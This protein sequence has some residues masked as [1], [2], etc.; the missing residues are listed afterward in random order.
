M[1]EE[2]RIEKDKEAVQKMIGA[3]SAMEAS[4]R[5]IERLRE[6]IRRMSSA[7]QDCMKVVGSDAYVRAYRKPDGEG[8]KES[9]VVSVKAI[10]QFVVNTAAKALS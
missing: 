3:K 9:A 1:T 4:I 8:A 7:H 5:E 10:S 2:E 6:T